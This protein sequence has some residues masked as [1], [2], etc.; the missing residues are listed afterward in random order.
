MQARPLTE[1]QLVRVDDGLDFGDGQA[2]H[3][4]LQAQVR[5]DEGRD[6]AD[7]A[8]AQPGRHVLGLVRHEERHRVPLNVARALEH[9]RYSVA[10]L[11]DLKQSQKGAGSNA[12]SGARLVESMIRIG[13]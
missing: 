8:Q 12:V 9:R 10:V 3:Q 7:L 4:R 1:S 2:V 11:I 13:I 6:D 5:V